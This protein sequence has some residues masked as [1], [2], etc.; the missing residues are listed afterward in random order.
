M[1]HRPPGENAGLVPSFTSDTQDEDTEAQRDISKVSEP[2][3]GRTPAGGPLS[4]LPHHS[5]GQQWAPEERL[6][7]PLPYSR[8][9]LVILATNPGLDAPSP[10]PETIASSSR[11]TTT[12]YGLAIILSSATSL[13][14]VGQSPSVGASLP[15][16]DSRAEVLINQ[17]PDEE[18][19][20]LG[21]RAGKVQ[22][23]EAAQ[24]SAT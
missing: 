7:P 12:Q 4:W 13:A 3:R 18:L 10:N 16:R 17:R 21:E 19:S 9:F 24:F 6:T 20:L 8:P 15:D 1:V 5:R 2:G 11:A 23:F 22:G 14:G